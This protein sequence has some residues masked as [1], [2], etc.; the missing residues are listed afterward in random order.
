MVVMTIGYVDLPEKISEIQNLK[1]TL[2]ELQKKK[3]TTTISSRKKVFFVA[4]L[5]RSEE[6]LNTFILENN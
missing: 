3:I 4:D 5:R 1:K 2:Y 6:I